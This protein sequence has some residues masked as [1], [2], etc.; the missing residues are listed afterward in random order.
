LRLKKKTVPAKATRDKVD[1]SRKLV[2]LL[3][4]FCAILFVVS[5]VMGAGL[6][7]SDSRIA[8]L[9]NRITGLD[10]TYVVLSEQIRQLSSSPAFIEQAHVEYTPATPPLQNGIG[11]D[12]D[13]S[14]EYVAENPPA[15]PEQPA[16]PVFANVP[17]RYVVQ[18]GDSLYQI[19]R[20]FYGTTDMVQRI[21]ELNNITD[22]NNITA[23]MELLLPQY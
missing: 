22:A 18:A 11:E 14:Y 1:D 23:G 4:G 5:F 8:A 12:V 7:Q 17:E 3:I 10:T 20:M 6:I 16:R 2:N 21:M 9:E 15:T 19:S 13:E